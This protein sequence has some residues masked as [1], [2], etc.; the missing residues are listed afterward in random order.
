MTVC[1]LVGKVTERCT[2]LLCD[3]GKLITPELGNKIL[4]KHPRIFAQRKEVVKRNLCEAYIPHGKKRRLNG[5]MDKHQCRKQWL[6]ELLSKEG[7]VAAM[8]LKLETDPNYISSLLGPSSKKEV[9]DDIA[10]RAEHAY[11]LPPGAL[12]LP[13]EGAQKLVE[14]ADGMNDE[15]IGRVLEFMRFVKSTKN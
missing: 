8:A 10:S 13:S 15:A 12:D 2:G 9:G 5:G 7:S 6:R 14:E 1:D 4:D 3:S 11:G